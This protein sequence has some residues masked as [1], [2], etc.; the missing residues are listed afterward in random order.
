ML[1]LVVPSHHGEPP[2]KLKQGTKVGRLV[3]AQW[4]AI[5]ALLRSLA[6]EDPCGQARRTMAR[7]LRLVGRADSVRN[8]E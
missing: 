7:D 5:D 6:H 8:R 2:R 3:T 1:R 4:L